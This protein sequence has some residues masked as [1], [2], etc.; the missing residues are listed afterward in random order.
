[1]CLTSVSHWK[2]HKIPKENIK[3]LPRNSLRTQ[4]WRFK[5]GFPA[6]D[7]TQKAW[8]Y[9][10]QP[11][12]NR[13]LLKMVE[14]THPSDPH[15][16]HKIFHKAIHSLREKC[17]IRP[18]NN[19]K[20]SKV[21]SCNSNFRNMGQACEAWGEPYLKPGFTSISSMPI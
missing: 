3:F 7:P 21:T 20:I 2:K 9:H 10:Y 15:A 1:M 14:Y 17:R 18:N 12:V 16:F 5:F 19:Q 4:S 6:V 13:A 8:L 11:G